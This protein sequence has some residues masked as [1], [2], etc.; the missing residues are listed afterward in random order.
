[1][2]F[3]YI[4]EEN[5][6][7]IDKLLSKSSYKEKIINDTENPSKISPTTFAILNNLPDM[8]QHLQQLGANLFAPNEEGN[9]LLHIAAFYKNLDAVKFALENNSMI[10]ALNLEGDT[11]LFYAVIKESPE[12]IEFLLSKGASDVIMN[13][14]GL[15]PIHEAVITGNL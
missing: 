8:T 9:S 11:P 3:F 5:K 2:L 12:I 6:T 14:E 7:A 4:S 15:Y 13:K 1:L 10:D